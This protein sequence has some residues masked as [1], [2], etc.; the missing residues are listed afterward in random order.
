MTLVRGRV[1][2][3]TISPHALAETLPNYRDIIK[4]SREGATIH[5]IAYVAQEAWLRNATIRENILFGEP[6][7]LER[8]EEVLRICALKP[9]LRILAAGDMSEVGERGIALSGGQK[10]RVALARA[11]Y[12][13]RRILLVDDCLSAVDAHTAKHILVEC[14][15][16]SSRIMQERTRVLVTHHVAMC[17]PYAQ[18]MV[19]VNGGRITL[20]G[21]PAE[22]RNSNSLSSALIESLDNK[23]NRFTAKQNNNNKKNISVNDRKSEDE[24]N[25]EHLQKLAVKQGIDPNADLS[26]LQGI[27][28][29]DEERE[30][31]YVKFEVW[32]AFMKMCGSYMFWAWLI[33]ILLAS[34]AITGLRSFWV[35]MWVESTNSSASGLNTP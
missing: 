3:P 9:D 10:Q 27:L 26:M 34:E 29:K 19:M 17:L 8:Y 12:S 14:L 32:K 6:Y 5:D 16:G 22:L 24:Y 20:K 11:V 30:I 13:S 33:M 23:N 4:L 35:K 18:Y 7:D 25:K 31:G 1:L 15:S 21:T 2:L 28:I